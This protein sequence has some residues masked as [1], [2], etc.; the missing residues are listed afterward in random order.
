MQ[1]KNKETQTQLKTWALTKPLMFSIVFLGLGLILSLI[2]SA[3]QTFLNME[4]MALM[5][6]C[7]FMIFVLSIWYMIKKLPHNE[8]NQKDFVAIT[9]ATSLIAILSS[10]IAILGLGSN[11]EILKIK[12][13][14]AYLQH[15]TLFFAVFTFIL[16]VSI[17]LLGV[18]IS[19]I[20]AKYKRSVSLG[21]SPWKAILSMPFGFFLLWTPGYLFKGTSTI[22]SNLQIKCKWFTRLNDW[23][24]KNFNNTLVAFLFLLFCKCFITGI[25]TIL[26]SGAL[27][28][29]FALW[30]TKRKADFFK[31]INRGYALTAVGINLAMILAILSQTRLF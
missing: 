22:K 15:P 23:V 5:Y 2:F 13:M 9:N 8:M 27:L 10:F 29:L 11:G 14:M 17:Y 30:Y 21:I 25:P 19:G 7:V 18:S 3:I 16:F 12:I 26:L 28:L 1:T 4:S 6:I 24:L 31:D 20:Y